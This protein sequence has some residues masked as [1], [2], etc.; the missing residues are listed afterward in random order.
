MVPLTP[1]TE[2][3][4]PLP[5]Y[6]FYIHSDILY[7]F[8]VSLFIACLCYLEGKLHEE[9]IFVRLFIAASPLPQGEL[10]TGGAQALFME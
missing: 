8:L 3:P 5:C 9:G 4:L 7:A 10:G 6:I 1:T 2:R